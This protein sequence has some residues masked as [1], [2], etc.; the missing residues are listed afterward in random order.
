ML[1]RLNAPCTLIVKET[2][3]VEEHVAARSNDSPYFMALEWLTRQ[4][5][6]SAEAAD[7]IKNLE[8]AAKVQFI[9]D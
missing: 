8:V 5:S 7:P 4:R 1:V 6:N 2:A 3:K 9:S